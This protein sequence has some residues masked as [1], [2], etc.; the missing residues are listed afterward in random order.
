MTDNKNG[1]IYDKL[2][3]KSQLK[4]L[5]YQNTYEVFQEFKKV[6]D[7]IRIETDKRLNKEGL[8]FNIEFRDKGGFEFE[9]RFSG[10][11]LIFNMHTNV[12]EF[13]RVHE[14]MKTPYILEDSQRSYSGVINIYNFLA[15]SFRYNRM[16]DIGYLV[17]RIFINKERFFLVEGKHQNKFYYNQFMHEA[18]N[19]QAMRDIIEAAM[20]YSIDFDL[21]VPPYDMIKE[22]TVSDMMEN[23]FNMKIRTGKRMGFKFQ[24]DHDQQKKEGA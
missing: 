2:K 8:P 5:V 20:R 17:A 12:F 4:R 13:S 9:L 3:A 19:E 24:A 10:D 14:V 21:L 6:A 7:Q 22:T 11:T 23:S 18:I 1:S 15:D 16:N